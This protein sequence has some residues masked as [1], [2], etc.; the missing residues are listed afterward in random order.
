MSSECW[1][2][3]SAIVGQ[4]KGEAKLYLNS[5]V[6]G[7]S[8]GPY[9]TNAEG[10]DPEFAVCAARFVKDL[11]AKD[12][13]FYVVSMFRSSAHQAY[14]CGGGCPPAPRPCGEPGKSKHQSGRAVDIGNGQRIIPEWVH[15]MA[16]GYGIRFPVNGDSGHMEPIPGSKCADANFKPTDTTGPM[17]PT[18]R[19]ADAIRNLLK[20]P[21]APPPSS[22]PS[23]SG[24]PN[25]SGI[26]GAFQTPT[27]GSCIPQFFCAGSTYY[28]KTSSCADQVYQR[29]EY[30]C[31][32]N[33][34]C[35]AGP[36]T[37]TTTIQNTNTNQ[38]T[39]GSTATSTYDLI[40]S[41][42]TT[43]TTTQTIAPIPLNPGTAHGTVLQPQQTPSGIVYVP[44]NSAT[45]L[46][47]QETFT[48]NDLSGSLPYGQQQT[49]Y[50]A[51]LN[52]I[53]NTILTLMNYLRPFGGAPGPIHFE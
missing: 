9:K 39:D 12:P 47:V 14:L 34:T 42:A 43:S 45:G 22:L 33:T 37:G 2:P 36:N 44:V 51:T 28:Y 23:T 20:P 25:Q 52:A 11:R 16:Q 7:G 30:G 1:D 13:R 49:G 24:S 26:G 8:C 10:L 46:P 48:S 6:K 50:N 29:C 4:D 17:T 27:S 53:K 35:A 32:D 5:V 31:A 40:G 3:K 18:A 15:Q 19:V 41:Y 21:Q 38:N